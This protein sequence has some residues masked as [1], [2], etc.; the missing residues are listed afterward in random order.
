MAM[1]NSTHDSL[2][3]QIPGSRLDHAVRDEPENNN[4]YMFETPL[5]PEELLLNETAAPK[6]F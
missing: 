6:Q 3:V 2:L 1:V 4:F 5:C